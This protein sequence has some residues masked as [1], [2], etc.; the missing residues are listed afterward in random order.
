MRYQF[1]AKKVHFLSPKHASRCFANEF[2][3]NY[4][5]ESFDGDSFVNQSRFDACAVHR[6]WDWYSDN[7]DS[8]QLLTYDSVYSYL[9]TTIS[10]TTPGHRRSWLICPSPDPIVHLALTSKSI[11]NFSGKRF[12][13]YCFLSAGGF[14]FM[15]SLSHVDRHKYRRIEGLKSASWKRR[16]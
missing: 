12:W 8:Y 1:F 16:T 5:Q 15:L 7:F 3:Q 13:R 11:L 2:S 9:F 10:V 4:C 14:N 6:W